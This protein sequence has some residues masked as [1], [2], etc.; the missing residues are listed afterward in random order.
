LVQLRRVGGKALGEGD[1]FDRW[2]HGL[3]PSE[4]CRHGVDQQRPVEFVVRRKEPNVVK[5]LHAGVCQPK[6]DHGVK[7]LGDARFSGVGSKLRGRVIEQRRQLRQ[8]WL[9][10]RR[11]AEADIDLHRNLRVAEPCDEP[12]AYAVVNSIFSDGLCDDGLALENDAVVGNSRTGD[13]SENLRQAGKVGGTAA[14]QVEVLRGS[15][16]LV[17][18]NDEEQRALEHELVRVRRSRQ[19]VEQPFEHVSD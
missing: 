10:N 5:V 16:R 18:P 1:G 14:E 12:Q 13:V 9:G 2:W 7:L 15:M 11:V 17:R 3:A 8:L 4:G 19:S 6:V